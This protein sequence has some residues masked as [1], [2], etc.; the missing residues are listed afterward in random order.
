MKLHDEYLCIV[1]FG[2]IAKKHY[3]IISKL[4]PKIKIIIISKNQKK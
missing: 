4:Y 2:N 1:S 3:N